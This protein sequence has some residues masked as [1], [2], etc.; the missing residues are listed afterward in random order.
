MYTTNVKVTLKTYV[1]YDDKSLDMKQSGKISCSAK[2][3]LT[4][5]LKS[6]DLA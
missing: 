1:A 3:S 5:I 4:R 2:L 6:Q